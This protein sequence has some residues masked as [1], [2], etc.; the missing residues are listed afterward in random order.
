MTAERLQKIMARGGV[1]SRRA[2]EELIA[3]GRVRVN[4]KIV[5]E[6]GATADARRDKIELDG[7][8][9]LRE[10][11][12]Y[13]VL[14]KPRG[15]MSTMSDPEGRPTIVELLKKLDG[16]VFPVGRLDFA[17]S[18]VL[19]ITNDG[20][21]SNALTHPS[22]RVPKTYVVKV[23]GEMTEREMEQWRK[24]IQLED[25]MTQP[26]ELV[27]DRYEDK[28][29]WFELTIYEGRN[30]QIRR[31]G[32]ATGFEVMRLSRLSF[33]GISG[34]KLKPGAVRHLSYRELVDLKKVF[35]VPR[36]TA[37]SGLD[38]EDAK[39]LK[40][41]VKLRGNKNKIGRAHV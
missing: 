11:F 9:V 21:F 26:A 36:K 41:P 30:Q 1:A 17:T 25:G 31:M 28:K 16:R 22:K 29:T 35:G 19:L 33:A 18:G 20:E 40:K 34:E 24:G 6:L 10:S 5:T 3:A 2:C 14:Q 38:I 27:F 13:A 39:A 4:G 15:Y 7:K 37:A 23:Q 12:V 8:L 32:E